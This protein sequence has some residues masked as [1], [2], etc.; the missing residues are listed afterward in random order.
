MLMRRAHGFVYKSPY[1]ADFDNPNGKG[2]L[3]LYS[4]DLGFSGKLDGE[5]FVKSADVAHAFQFI[6]K[7]PSNKAWKTNDKVTISGYE[8][9]IQG[10]IRIIQP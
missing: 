9:N 2:Q 10:A 4:R 7:N 6:N 5:S 3:R 8:I 1:Q